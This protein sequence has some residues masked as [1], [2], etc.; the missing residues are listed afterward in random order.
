M[1]S[2]LPEYAKGHIDALT[3]AQMKIW[4][5]NVIQDLL[6]PVIDDR[7]QEDFLDLFVPGRILCILRV[8]R[9]RRGRSAVMEE[10]ENRRWKI[11]F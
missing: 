9:I 7:Y 6:D 2:R 5:Y 10:W 3:G 11:L 4:G 1:I 8:K